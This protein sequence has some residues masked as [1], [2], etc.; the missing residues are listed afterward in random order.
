MKP[1]RF[2]ANEPARLAGYRVNNVGNNDWN[3]F[4]LNE[5]DAYEELILALKRL[6]HGLCAYCEIS[7]ETKNCPDHQIEHFLPK[8]IA[9][10]EHR[11][12]D[13]RNMLACCCGGG[14]S[15]FR[16]RDHFT[17]P[18][19]E[20]LSCG[21]KKETSL[22]EVDPRL[23]PPG[24][25]MFILLADGMF[26]A[27]GPGCQAAGLDPAQV[28]RVIELLGLNCPRLKNARKRVFDRVNSDLLES[29][30]S[31]LA[32]IYLLPNE[33]DVLLPFF[34]TIRIA[35]QPDAEVILSQV[36]KPWI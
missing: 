20:N 14:A 36:P 4:R 31:D 29:S 3:S 13:Y 18:A 7:L 21:Q 25:I 2:L 8:S 16:D 11:A 19:H 1:I 32:R 28:T 34:T 33:H 23:I 26:E 30:A 22:A 10:Y 9:E 27:N 12:L 17:P 35:L 15:H 6:Q 5:R 24:A